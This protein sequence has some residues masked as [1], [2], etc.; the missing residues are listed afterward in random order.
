[1]KQS[2]ISAEERLIHAHKYD[3]PRVFHM[4]YI[5]V[6]SGSLAGTA[7]AFYHTRFVSI[8][9]VMNGIMTHSVSTS[10]SLLYAFYPFVLSLLLAT[11]VIGF[12]LYPVILFSRGFILSLQALL[13]FDS[14]A[15]L[16]EAF[17][18]VVPFALLSL[19]S[20]F[21]IGN[22]VLLSSWTLYHLKNN[23]YSDTASV[24]QALVLTLMAA[25]SRIYI[26]ALIH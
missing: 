23:D 7:Y 19:S 17:A 22:D 24:F 15:R 10:T 18:S 8:D 21:L 16:N 13:L 2:F 1:M 12:Y 25:L 3:G 26:P 4:Q 20:L 14:Q 6:M 5:F 9:T 11:S